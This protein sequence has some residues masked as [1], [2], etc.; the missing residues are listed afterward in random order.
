LGDGDGF[1]GLIDAV[2]SAEAAEVVGVKRLNPKGNAVDAGLGVA[3]EAGGLDGAGVG[4]QGDLDVVGKGPGGADAVEDPL[5]GGGLHQ[6]RGAAAEEDGVEDAALGQGADAVDF[7]FEGAEPLSLVDAG[8]D[9][10]VEVAVGAFRLAEGP[11]EVEAEAGVAPVVH[12]GNR[13]ATSFW[14]ASAR[15]ERRFF[16]Q[17]SISPKV[18][19]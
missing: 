2:H 19:L 17:R 4:F 16:S 1:G 11:V 15:W 5:D 13:A 10:A 7:E 6:G 12:Q 14:K 18:W 8:G 9:V 3:V